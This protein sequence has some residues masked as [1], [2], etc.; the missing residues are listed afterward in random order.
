MQWHWST[1]TSR[2]MQSYR[3][4]AWKPWGPVAGTANK[5]KASMRNLAITLALALLE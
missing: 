4:I 3:P 2:E 1:Y 5:V